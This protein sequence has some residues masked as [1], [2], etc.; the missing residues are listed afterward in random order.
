MNEELKYTLG[1]N[2]VTFSILV[3]VTN[4]PCIVTDFRC[5]I[6]DKTSFK[7]E[8]RFKI[9]FCSN[10]MPYFF[11]KILKFDVKSPF[12]RSSHEDKSLI[13]NF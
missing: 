4:C 7:T 3:N 5:V 6:Q 2:A 13:T 9:D 1:Q 8:T 11:G 12:L 10:Q